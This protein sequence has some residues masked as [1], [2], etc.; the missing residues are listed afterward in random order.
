MARWTIRDDDESREWKRKG[1]LLVRT[2]RGEDVAAQGPPSNLPSIVAQSSCRY[3]YL[4][5]L[6]SDRS[7]QKVNTNRRGQQSFKLPLAPICT[8]GMV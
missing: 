6:L 4:S 1:T 5:L 2:V 3:T 7:A 8:L